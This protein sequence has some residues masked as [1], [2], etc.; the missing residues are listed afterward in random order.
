MAGKIKIKHVNKSFVRRPIIKV[1]PKAA[2]AADEKKTTSDA[3]K[4]KK[5]PQTQSNKEEDKTDT[6]MLTQ[7]QLEQIEASVENLKPDVKVLKKDRGLIE[8][9][10][11]SKI[12]LTEDNRQVLND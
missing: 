2:P 6:A 8:R 12:V 5:S 4:V 10:E 1:V 11:S 9:T 3:P 7:E